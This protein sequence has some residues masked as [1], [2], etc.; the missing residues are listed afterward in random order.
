VAFADVD[1]L[2]QG[3]ALLGRDLADD[4]ALA[5]LF[6]SEDDHVVTLL[7]A[8]EGHRTSGAREMIFM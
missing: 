3:R 6:A 2:D 7:D 4:A 8:S 1:V 5:S